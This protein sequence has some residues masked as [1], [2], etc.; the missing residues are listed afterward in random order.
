[1]KL[2]PALLAALTI[3]A[4]AHADGRVAGDFSTDWAH[5]TVEKREL[6]PGL[7]L[8]HAS[9][10]N[11]VALTTPDGT[12]LVDPSF[13]QV[14]PTLKQ[15]LREMKAKPVR[16]VVD[17]HYHGDHSGGNGAFA[18]DG[19]I[20]ICQEN[21][22]PH[23]LLPRA[24]IFGEL[25]PPPPADSLPTLGYDGQLTIQLGGEEVTLFHPR[26][27]H[28][29]GDTIVYFRKANVVH[30]GD[31]FVNELFPYVDT[32]SGGTID[33]YMPV[34]DAV[35]ARIDDRTQVVPGHGP[36]ATKQQLKAY[37]DMLQTVRDRVAAGIAA[38][39]SLAQII[40]AQPT[41]E[42]D[43]RN[44][45]DRVDGAGFTAIVYKSLTGQEMDW[46]KP[47]Q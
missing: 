31:I 44:A 23:M 42:F 16:Y 22:R 18:A 5:L 19:A 33:G 14:A 4:A 12:L 27:S 40:A 38:G 13:A 6:A 46:R 9:G 20:T 2:F 24:G 43:A 3:P 25:S 15:A 17:T 32:G 7:Y 41:R 11:S 28:T 10:G 21:C 47:A 1:M 26:P 45:T 36:L 35:L 39:Q 34:I 8:L 29:D 30:M 37:R